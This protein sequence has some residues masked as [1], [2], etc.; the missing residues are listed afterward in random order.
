VAQLHDVF[1][2]ISFDN[3]DAFFFKSSFSSI[4]SETM[5][6]DLAIKTFS[7][8]RTLGI[9][10]FF[11]ASRVSAVILLQCLEQLNFL[12]HLSAMD[13]DA[14]PFV[15]AMNCARYSWCSITSTR[16]AC[17]RFRLSCQSGMDSN[18]SAR[19]FRRRSVLLSSAI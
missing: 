13:D 7:P 9:L 19:P 6:L 4:S 14:V 15:L 2:E 1:A 11:S 5:L 17:A 8:R 18:A 10:L 12:P 3:L 16:T